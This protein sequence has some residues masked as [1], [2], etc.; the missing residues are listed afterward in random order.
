M[1]ECGFGYKLGV[2]LSSASYQLR[3]F[4]EYLPPQP[5]QQR[6][7]WL[8]GGATFVPLWLSTNRSLSEAIYQTTLYQFSA[9]IE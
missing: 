4:M 9:A 2:A 6:R 8:G 1:G 7:G 3:L 5:W